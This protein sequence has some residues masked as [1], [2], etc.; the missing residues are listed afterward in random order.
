MSVKITPY[1]LDQSKLQADVS[2]KIGKNVVRKRWVIP[3]SVYASITPGKREKACENWAQ[4][5]LVELLSTEK[6]EITKSTTLDKFY[7]KWL[8][9]LGQ[10]VKATTVDNYDRAY[11][12]HIR[13]FWG[14]KE[15][16]ELSNMDLM[17]TYKTYLLNKTRKKVGRQKLIEDNGDFVGKNKKL[18]VSAKNNIQACLMSIVK[19][20]HSLTLISYLPQIKFEKREKTDIADK[21]Y[22]IGQQETILK[23]A[24]EM[25]PKIYAAF[26]LGLDC[27]F[28]RGEVLALTWDRIYKTYI[29]V[30]YN[31]N[32][33][34]GVVEI[35]S[36]KG[37]KA[38]DVAIS[39]RVALALGRIRPEVAI[40]RVFT[41]LMPWDLNK[42]VRKVLEKANAIDKTIVIS[43]NFHKFRHNCASNLADNNFYVVKIKNHMRH[44]SIDTTMIYIHTGS[45]EETKLVLDSI[46]QPIKKQKLE[47]V[48]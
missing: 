45:I 4:N 22:S 8:E 10:N 13:P 32:V 34:K 7:P 46:G 3:A 42:W 39:N 1:Q 47:L 21:K 6:D 38:A 23:C 19:L 44:Q 36:T 2:Y 9:Y 15:L 17:I 31:M 16:A 27:G 40:G 20:A 18:A 26:L 43:A 25:D 14:H 35:G 12:N 11:R 33:I 29:D 48:K 24:L 37:G 41:D 5:K 30:K 28:R